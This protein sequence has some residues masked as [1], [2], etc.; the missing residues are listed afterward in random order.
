MQKLDRECLEKVATAMDEYEKFVKNS[1]DLMPNTKR[2][3][4]LHSRNFV[5]WL[6]GEFVPGSNAR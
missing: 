4:L 5:R 3:Y 6:H 2:T 1:T